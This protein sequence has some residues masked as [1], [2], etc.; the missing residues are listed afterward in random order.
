MSRI[1]L[2][3]LVLAGA[4]AF[5]WAGDGAVG[6]V[7]GGE[8]DP[9][10]YW[11]VRDLR[12]GMKGVGRTVMVGT[13]LEDFGVEVLGVMRD[14]SPGRDM[15]LC[16]LSGCNLEH[17]GIIQGMSGSPIYID[18][19]L[20]GAVAFAWEFGKDPIAGVTPFSQMV[21]YV[22]AA[23]RRLAAENLAPDQ[24]PRTV[25]LDASA[26]DR[27]APLP[28]L[29]AESGSHGS[30]TTP[31]AG[32][33]LAGMLPIATPLS[34]T[35]FSPRALAYLSERLGPLGMAAAPG[36]HVPDDILAQEANQT[37][38]P[39]S[40]ISVAMVMGD[41]DISGIGT[42]TH[43]EGDRVYAFGHPMLSLGRCEFPMMTGYI[44][45]VYPRSSVSMKLGSPLRV[46]GVL[47]SDVS[48]AV[49]GR[50]GQVPDMMP[51]TV[52]VRSGPYSEPKHYEVQIAREPNMLASFVS[53]VLSSALDTEGNLP[54]ELTARIEAIIRIK[55]HEPL[56]VKETLSGPRYTGP[57]GPTA[58]LSSVSSTVN[59]LARNPFRSIRIEG[60]DCKILLNPRRE[61]AE[62]D[63]IRLLN[64]RIE[65]GQTLRLNA[66]LRPYKG[67]RRTQT[68]ELAIP[69]DF[70]EGSHELVVCD[71]TRS[72]QRRMRNTPGL[73]EPKN[74]EAL[75][76][77]L[78][79]R[80]EPTRT[81][82]FLHVSR[83]GKGLAVSGQAMPDLPGS[84]RSILT[85]PRSTGEPPVQSDLTAAI[86]TPW[87]VEGSQS[88]HFTVSR[89]PGL[90]AIRGTP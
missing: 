40:P 82:L 35:G 32:G 71:M 89:D 27:D 84:V 53:S 28:A 77:L 45:T 49:S 11:N 3:T 43:V 52:E 44:H 30:A 90:T 13:K 50:L 18:D 22:R 59:L 61:L 17:A 6:R 86:E 85:S 2:R 33:S 14:V 5:L 12:P 80:A 74:S 70:P 24:G 20:V 62:L 66:I 10:T 81:A 72:L 60:I 65:P 15:I 21:E 48:T 54:E 37:L 73:L 9:T 46:V 68:L 57:L 55:D 29:V 78:R 23:D 34:A 83:P 67:E 26:W 31:M 39:G 4:S 76:T 1:W 56:I 51:M 42:V 58:L 19:K 69:A 64:D 75:I 87:V 16:R 79:E 38:H 36:G 8:P 41:F 63:T 88:I 25:A 47:D 7:R